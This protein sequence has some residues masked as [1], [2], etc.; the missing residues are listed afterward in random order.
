MFSVLVLVLVAERAGGGGIVTSSSVGLEAGKGGRLA[1]AGVVTA[2]GT[3]VISPVAISGTAEN[4]A[5][6]NSI[7]LHQSN[8]VCSTSMITP[9]SPLV[10]LSAAPGLSSPS[11]RFCDPMRLIIYDIISLTLRNSIRV[12]APSK[13]D[14]ISAITGFHNIYTEF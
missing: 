11:G 13:A 10:M 2:L 1:A 12:V 6:S 5:S 8:R 4:S 7:T 3:D 14:T 9:S